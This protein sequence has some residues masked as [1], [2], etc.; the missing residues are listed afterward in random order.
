ML[1]RTLK[2]LVLAWVALAL[3]APLYARELV[4]AFSQSGGYS[5]NGWFWLR[6]TDPGTVTYTFNDGNTAKDVARRAPIRCASFQIPVVA[7]VT[8]AKGGGAGHDKVIKMTV[9][10]EG[11][12]E[13]PLG[14]WVVVNKTSAQPVLALNNPAAVGPSNPPGAGY[15]ANANLAVPAAVCENF[16]LTGNLVVTYTY[17]KDVRAS[18]CCPA[19]AKQAAFLDHHVAFN[20]PNEWNKDEK[21]RKLRSLVLSY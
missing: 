5:L 2:L 15:Q 20:N 4:P 16:K 6:P 12:Y 1:N 9:T 18:S 3:C 19:T 14:R 13:G 17:G 11:K 21:A 7:L 10:S 8:E